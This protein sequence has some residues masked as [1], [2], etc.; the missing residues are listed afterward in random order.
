MTDEE[1]ER[2]AE[3]YET[4]VCGIHANSK[5]RQAYKDGYKEG[6]RIESDLIFESWCKDPSSPCGFLL[7]REAEIEAL[8]NTIEQMKNCDNCKHSWKIAY[9]EIFDYDSSLLQEPCRTCYDY[10]KWEIKR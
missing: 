3:M 1:L 6:R 4:Q 9:L 7:K 10:D 2:K 5:L 8:K